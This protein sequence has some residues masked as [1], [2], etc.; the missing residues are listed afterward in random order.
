VRWYLDNEHWW[1]EIL[2][3]SNAADRR[4]LSV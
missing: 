3:H 1:R 2:D 4:G